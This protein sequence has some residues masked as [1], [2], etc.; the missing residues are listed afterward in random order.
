MRVLLHTPLKPPDSPTPS[1]DREMARGLRRLLRRL[2]HTVVMPALSRVAAGVPAPQ[3]HL[4][5]ERRARS[6]AR[7]LI[8]HPAGAP[9]RTLRSLAHLPLLL[10]QAR[11]AGPD[12][13]PGA[14]RVLCA[15]R[16]LACAT[17]RPGAD[18]A[19]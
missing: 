9:S 17:S 19:R 2:G 16:G 15:G 14:R 5:L 1:G 12:R 18:A 6:Q 11:L 4:A 10:P 3:D 8:A 13:H 7:R